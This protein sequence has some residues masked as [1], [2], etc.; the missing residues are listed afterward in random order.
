MAGSSRVIDLHAHA[1]LEAGF[2]QAGRYGPETGEEGGVPFFRIG[3]FRMK[4]MSY[5]GT[6]FMDVQ[7]RLELMDT[8]GV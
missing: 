2:N 7:K 6:V 8:L 3:E 4:P 5:R 1:V